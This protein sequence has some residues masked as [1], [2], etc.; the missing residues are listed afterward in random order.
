MLNSYRPFFRLFFLPVLIAFAVAGPSQA[1]ADTAKSKFYAAERCYQHLKK[2]PSLQ[3]YR[4]RW[5]RCINKYLEVHR[6]NP[7]G[8]WAA[9]GLYRAAVLHTELY[10]HSYYSGDK[11]EA[12]D[13]FDRIMRGY[14][15]SQYTPKAAVAK[16]RLLQGKKTKTTASGESDARR[17]Y[18]KARQNTGKSSEIRS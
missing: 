4:D 5:F 18:K 6:T 10:G 2:N 3:K 9:A 15:K 12:V 14:P 13:L 8:P 7:R 1:L 11:K 17:W 16:K